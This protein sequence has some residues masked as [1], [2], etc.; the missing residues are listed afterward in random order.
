MRVGMGQLRRA[1]EGANWP[2][3]GREEELAILRQLRTSTPA[4]SAVITGPPGVGKTRL[5]DVALT[6]AA[7]QGWTTLAIQGSAGYSRVPLGRSGP[8][9]GSPTPVN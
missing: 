4:V 9:Y 1:T 3:V 2:L 8:C 5:A 7:G 6:E